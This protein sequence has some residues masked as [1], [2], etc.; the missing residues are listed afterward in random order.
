MK[1]LILMT[2]LLTLSA[3]LMADCRPLLSQGD[4]AQQKLSLAIYGAYIYKGNSTVG[5]AFEDLSKKVN[6]QLDKDITTPEL[7]E[8][9]LQTNMAKKFCTSANIRAYAKSL[10]QEITAHPEI[11][12]AKVIVPY[13]VVENTDTDLVQGMFPNLYKKRDAPILNI[14]LVYYGSYYQAADLERIQ[15]LLEKRWNISTDQAL[16][17]KTVFKSVIPFKNNLLNFPDY[18]QKEVTDPERL[19]RLWYYDNVGA[20]IL[21]EVYKQVKSSEELKGDLANIDAL[22]IVTG[23]QFEALGFASGR[24]AATENP[25][26]IA[27]GVPGGG[28]VEFVSDERVVD[29]L[30]HEIGHTLFLDHTAT[31]C[32]ELDYKEAQACCAQ[33]P[34][35][36]DVM[37]YCR[38]R[39]KVDQNFFNKFEACSLRTIKNKIVPA[40]LS[41]GS[42]SIKDREKCE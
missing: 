21:E 1:K 9:V 38:D 6:R 20:G 12:K 22:V 27:W 17:L 15:E 24:I 7:A 34:S 10:A 16:K 4:K 19:Q 5:S 23:A 36:N 13:S 32:S 41:G 40:L 25:M 18:S 3:N 33:S 31:H 42:W 39:S 8:A 37:S 11:L 35:R 2:C 28:R 26:E 30:I 14:G 29:E